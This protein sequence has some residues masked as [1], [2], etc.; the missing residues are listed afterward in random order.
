MIK[1]RISYKP[2]AGILIM[3]LLAGCGGA[4]PSPS[5]TATLASPSSTPE[6]ASISTLTL[7]P[8][9]ATHTLAATITA[10]PLA[11]G[12]SPTPAHM[13]AGP[14]V[15]WHLV[16]LS[17]STGWGLGSAYAAQ[18]EKDVDVKV[19]LNDFA[20]GDLSAADVVNALQT[21][22]SSI[23]KLEN[24][25][26]AMADADV[27]VLAPGPLGSLQDATFGN[28]ERCVGNMAGTPEL[29]SPNG[30]D[31]YTADLETIWGKIFEL[32]SG[33]PT[34][35]RGMDDA[36]PFINRWKEKQIIN[37]CTICWE[38]YSNA[39]RQAAEVFHIPFLSRYDIYN[40]VNHDLDAGQQGYIG[41]DGIHPN[42]LAQ[43]RTAELL[44]EMG[45][46]AVTPP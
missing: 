34:I 22:K 35:L 42:G 17:E 3:L 24:L 12:A 9:I 20:I 37:T 8:P 33:K 21:G 30:F 16:V 18:I 29:C 31:G 13:L 1:L 40:G 10:H 27:I 23:P 25:P 7:I 41:G 4:T 44:A 11:I 19:T 2:A 43:Q 38:T 26:A 15:E 28:I 46:E 14:E 36:S 32:R 6:P 5:G 39:A 45:Y